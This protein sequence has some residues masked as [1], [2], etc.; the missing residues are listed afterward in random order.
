[1]DSDKRSYK[2]DFK[3]LDGC[4][5]AATRYQAVCGRAFKKQ[6]GGTGG[7]EKVLLP[8]SSFSPFFPSAF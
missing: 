4:L 5:Q 2:I 8:S 6:D 1:M 3:A 7:A